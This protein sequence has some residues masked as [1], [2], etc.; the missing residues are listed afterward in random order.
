VA[1]ASVLDEDLPHAMRRDS[2]E[3]RATL[4]IRLLSTN[5]TQ[6]KVVN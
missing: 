6:V 4:P 1:P 2:E 3:V 5:K